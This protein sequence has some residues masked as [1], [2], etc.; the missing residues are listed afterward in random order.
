[1]SESLRTASLSDDAIPDRSVIDNEH[2]SVGTR[3]PTRRPPL[4]ARPQSWHPYGP[5]E[6]P[7]EATSRSIGVHSILNPPSQST[8]E[9]TVSS[10]LDRRS[11][12]GA[13]SPRPQK[14]SS[15]LIRPMHSIMQHPLSPRSTG[16]PPINPGSPSARFVGG[17]RSGQSSVAQSPMVPHE[18]PLGLRQ[19]SASSPLP[20]DATLRPLA[21]LPVSQAPGVASLHNTP[22][23]HSRRTST[24]PPAQLTNPHSQ[25]TSPTTPH[26][27]YSHFGRVSPPG[28][29][30]SVPPNIA[31][32]SAA[33]T[34]YMPMET[35]P[36]SG[37]VTTVPRSTAEETTAGMT[38]Q[39]PGTPGSTSSLGPLIPCVLDLK[40]GSTSQAEKRKANSDASRR[41]R[42]RKRN[43]LQLEQRLT[44]QHDE[45]RRQGEEIRILIQQRDHY[46]S[47]RDFFRDHFGRSSSLSQ[48]PARPSS[49]RS[50]SSATPSILPA[51]S[52]ELPPATTWSSGDAMR[53]VADT[54]AQ[55]ASAPV[56]R[57]QGSWAGTPASYPAV[58][59]ASAPPTIGRDAAPSGPPVSG[60][61][62][63]PFQGS[64]SRQ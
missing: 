26:S 11:I 40:S 28:T 60:E 63:P 48:F 47:E 52:S 64:W 10:N 51:P 36:R 21:S 12:S 15:P 29:N 30:A 59:H 38:T 42:N 4:R 50:V 56:T 24:G 16:R 53:A 45:I 9:S 35:L 55:P 57:P 49:P 7:L 6:P 2:G 46:R 27:T 14:G 39:G 37:S 61:S 41:F 19:T 5:V 1:M 17:G 31:P 18:P 54:H 25:E 22:N 8:M 43:E 58:A 20:M 13:T 3:H 32:Y 44:A 34:P 23:V 62:L 33:S